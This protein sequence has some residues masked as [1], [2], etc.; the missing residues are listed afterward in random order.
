MTIEE[1]ASK[2]ASIRGVAPRPGA[3]ADE[4]LAT[5]RRLGRTIPSEL[6]QLVEVMDG[7]DG[8]T[9]PNQSWTT[10]WPLRRWRTVAGSGSTPY[11][12]E[13]II[14]AD[15]CQESWWYAFDSAD[16]GTVRVLKINGPDGVVSESL[17]EFLEAVLFDDPKIY[18]TLNGLG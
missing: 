17:A 7:C 11:Y 16:A 13:A 12:T 14:F 1:L 2:I 15:Y 10:F 5:E 4:I 6:K 18:G 8:E 9:P 3:T